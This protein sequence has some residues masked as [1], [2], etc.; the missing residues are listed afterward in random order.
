MAQY[1]H[2]SYLENHDSEAFDRLH[3]PGD[4]TPHSGIYR[5]EGC[6]REIASNLGNPL[7]SQ[8]GTQHDPSIHGTVRWRMIVHAEG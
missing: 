1:K 5:C 6:G 7:P 4:V 2:A 8:N 3:G